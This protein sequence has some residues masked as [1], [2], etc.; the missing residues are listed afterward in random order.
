MSFKDVSQ[1]LTSTITIKAVKG[2]RLPAALDSELSQKRSINWLRNCTKCISS[3]QRPNYSNFNRAIN[4]VFLGKRISAQLIKLW[5]RGRVIA[6]P[7]FALLK[8][9]KFHLKQQSSD[10]LTESRCSHSEESYLTWTLLNPPALFSF[11]HWDHF[12]SSWPPAHS[13]SSP[14]SSS[15]PLPR[16]L[17]G[18]FWWMSRTVIPQVQSRPCVGLAPLTWNHCRILTACL[19]HMSLKLWL[20][21]QATRRTLQNLCPVKAQHKPACVISQLGHGPLWFKTF[22]TDGCS[23]SLF[24]FLFLLKVIA[25]PQL[26][27]FSLIHSV[28]MVFT[29]LSVLPVQE[30]DR[31]NKACH[32]VWMNMNLLGGRLF[33]SL[34]ACAEM[35]AVVP[36]V[37]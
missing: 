37:P 4:Q 1:A 31:H 32:I 26:S 28:S 17:P 27:V 8:S 5:V 33:R 13:S 16:F 21:L 19:A 6:E 2:K 24:N 15:S 35:T 12:S 7:F 14:S 18:V 9:I 11:H 36:E 25:L 23:F 22:F 10:C 34:S 29:L 20:P 30:S 3:E